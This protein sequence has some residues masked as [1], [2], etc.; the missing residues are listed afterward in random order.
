MPFF[1]RQ[2]NPRPIGFP[3]FSRALIDFQ[4]IRDEGDGPAV[5]GLHVL[6]DHLA[7]EGLVKA[8]ARFGGR[9]IYW[10]DLFP[11]IHRIHFS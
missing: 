5:G 3:A 10:L 11:S 9:E 1:Y 8:L 6:I 7:A 2:K 4:F